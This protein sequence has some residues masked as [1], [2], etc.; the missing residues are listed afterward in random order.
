MEPTDAA[1]V[2]ITGT[3]LTGEDEDWVDFVTFKNLLIFTN[4]RDPIQKWD[5]ISATVQPLGG[6]PPKARRIAVFQNH[7]VL[8]WID[9]TG[10]TPQ[11][12]QIRWSDLGLAEVWSGG[13][14][15][16]LS[17]VDEPSGVLE[18]VPLRDSLIAY[19]EDA[20]YVVEYTGFPFTMSTRRLAT[21]TG[22]FAPRMVVDVRD[23]HYFVGTDRQIYRL[24][25]SGPEPIGQAVR[26]GMFEELAYQYRHRS[27]GFL[28]DADNEVYFVIPTSTSK[29]PNVAYILSYLEDKWGRRE[30]PATAA[31]AKGVRQ[32]RDLTWD[33]VSTPW[34]ALT[35]TWDGTR[36]SKGA[37]IIM[38]GDASGKVYKHTVD[39]NDANGVAID[40]DLTTKM[41][42]FGDPTRHKRLER[43]HIFYEPQPSTTLSLY[44]LARESPSGAPTTYGPYSISLADTTAD[45]WIDLNITARFFQFRFRNNALNQPFAITGFVPVYY[46]REVA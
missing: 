31:S 28:N 26:V 17:F 38:H 27:F 41:F 32:L 29:D 9:P 39:Q 21:G 13:E 37:D 40:G 14:A 12:Q 22:I 4:G 42:D 30:L 44:V 34:D 20:I 46:M 16:A 5:G 7:V 43:L 8:A 25:L 24:T 1:P 36:S 23:A 3:A 11:P 10:T 15:G 33:E 19:K 6:S 45:A 2:D 18:I 35:T